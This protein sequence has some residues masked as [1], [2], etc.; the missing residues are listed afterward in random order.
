MKFTTLVSLFLFFFAG[1]FIYGHA[2]FVKW[3]GDY[4][5]LASNLS[6]TIAISSTLVALGI[7]FLWIG[8]NDKQKEKLK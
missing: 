4:Q 2:T 3:E 7:L 6:A 8:R 5:P 1:L